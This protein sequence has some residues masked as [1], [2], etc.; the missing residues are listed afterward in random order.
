M[1]FKNRYIKYIYTLH[2]LYVTLIFFL[3]KHCTFSFH[4]S[5]Y[6]ILYI[7]EDKMSY[8]LIEDKMSYKQNGL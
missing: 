8:K 2:N 5:L 1:L 6:I 7:F 4:C 3:L